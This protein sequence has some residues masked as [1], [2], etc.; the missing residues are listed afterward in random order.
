MDYKVYAACL[1]SYNAGILHGRWVDATLGADHIRTEIDAMLGESSQ[2]GAEEYAFH[3]YELGGVRISESED[4]DRV[5]DIGRLLSEG[6]YPE[7]VIAH[8]ADENEGADYERLIEI[9]G[10]AYVG[11]YE[12][13]EDYAR[14]FC[15]DCYDL[16]NVPD[17]FKGYID[18]ASMGRDWEISGDITAIDNG[19]KSVYIVRAY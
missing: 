3:D 8:I 12:S 9:L 6:D 15:E 18:Y 5:A 17:Y 16:S 11:E 14:Q 4:I 19:Y 7:A 13:L 2:P 10:D 1:A